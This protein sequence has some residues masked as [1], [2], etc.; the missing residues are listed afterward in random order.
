MLAAT[1]LAATL[2]VHAAASLTDALR[3]I[4][5]A[6]TRLSGVAVELNFAGSGTLARQIARGAPGDVFVSADEARVD[7]LE[8]AGLVASRRSI[9]SNALAVVGVPLERARRIAIAQP[10][11]V[12]AGIY[13]KRALMR[14]GVWERIAPRV[15]PT[16]NVRAALAAVE[17]GNADAAVVYRTDARLAKRAR[18]VAILEAPEI[19]Y[20]A[21]VLRDSH[22]PRRAAQFARYLTS[23][24]ARAVFRRYGFI[25]K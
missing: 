2:H 7:A 25:V 19:S 11:S 9:L 10:D 18:V 15:I 5:A 8:R 16:Q 24:S 3:E 23:P 14:A 13:A 6:W 4:A 12:P 21:A 1:L 17:A 22:D 20:S